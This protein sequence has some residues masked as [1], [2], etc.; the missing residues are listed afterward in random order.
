M[1]PVKKNKA[2]SPKKNRKITNLEMD[3]PKVPQNSVLLAAD[4][5]PTSNLS[6]KRIAWS[7]LCSLVTLKSQVNICSHFLKHLTPLA[8]YYGEMIWM[9]TR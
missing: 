3:R 4:D 8:I 9:V 7:Q 2:F 1:V 5:N 6:K